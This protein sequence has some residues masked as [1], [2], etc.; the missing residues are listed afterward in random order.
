VARS[1]VIAFGV[2]IRDG[3][4]HQALLR[5]LN[6]VAKSTGSTTWDFPAK[7]PV[8]HSVSIVYTKDAFLA[9]LDNADAYV[10]YDGHSR[11]GQGPA[12][13]P[14][15]TPECPDAAKYPTNPWGDNV[16]MGYH[17]VSVEIRDDILHHG[18][19]PPEYPVLS[20]TNPAHLLSPGVK[21]VI[22]RAQKISKPKCGTAHAWRELSACDPKLAGTANCR[23]SKTLAVRHYFNKRAR[24]SDYD[25]LVLRG[26]DDLTR[27]KLACAVLFMNSCSSA[28]HYRVPLE[29]HRTAVKSTCS[30]YF[31]QNVCSGP[32]TLTFVKLVLAGVDPTSKAG[33]TRFTKDMNGIWGSGQI[34]FVK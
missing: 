24:G 12:F 4:T 26:N 15:S 16:L 7:G 22:A 27:R 3:E 29:A 9:S 33:S 18:T 2:Q 30:F 13:G 19:D 8:T 14:A 31:T 32:Q 23:K 25:T 20:P 11:I 21:A 5:H 34:V 1:V 17:G 10:V 6:T 28:E